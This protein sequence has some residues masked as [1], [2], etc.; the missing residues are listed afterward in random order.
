LKAQAAIFVVGDLEYCCALACRVGTPR[1][2]QGRVYL[3][4]AKTELSGI[5]ARLGL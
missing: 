3:S 5:K 1:W 4:R 2:A